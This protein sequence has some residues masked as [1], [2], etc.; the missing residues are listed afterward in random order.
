M[1]PLAKEIGEIKTLLME[2]LSKDEDEIPYMTTSIKADTDN[3]DC[4]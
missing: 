1:L 4:N 2:R 3:G